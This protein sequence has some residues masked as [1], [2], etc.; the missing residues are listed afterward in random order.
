MKRQKAEAFQLL[1]PLALVDIV[2]VHDVMAA[3]V[4]FPFQGVVINH[5]RFDIRVAREL[6]HFRQGIAFQDGL[7]NGCMS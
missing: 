2:G 6:L 5:C 3:M 4:L 1:P 7:C